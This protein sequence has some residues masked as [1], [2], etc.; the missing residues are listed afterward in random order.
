[1]GI[2]RAHI[3]LGKAEAAEIG[4][5]IARSAALGCLAIAGLLFIGLLLPIGLTLFFGEW[6]FGSMGWGVVLGTLWWMGIAVTAVLVALRVTGVQWSLA[7]AFVVAIAFAILFAFRM[8]R[9]LWIWIGDQVNVAG[10]FGTA[11]AP[12]VGVL[13]VGIV[14]AI[15]GLALGARRGGGVAIGG[16]IGGF[17]LGALLGMF[18][19]INFDRKAGAATGIAIGLLVWP[20]LMAARLMRVGVDVED[21]KQRYYPDETVETAKETWQWVRERTPLGPKS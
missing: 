9:S 13:V 8:P 21:L 19:A 16:L 18:S 1:M 5:E 20:M 3:E 2:V 11:T 10:T 7:G 12:L 15:V 17:V 14:G 4:G 6:L